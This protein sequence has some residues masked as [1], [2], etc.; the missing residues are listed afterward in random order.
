MELAEAL[1]APWSGLAGSFPAPAGGMTIEKVGDMVKAYGKDTAL[2]IGGALLR[3]SP[4]QEVSARAF[5][6][7]L[8]KVVAS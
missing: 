3:H 2:L 8:E 7:A 4:D 1:R 5:V 6:T